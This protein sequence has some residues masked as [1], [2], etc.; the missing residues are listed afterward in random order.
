MPVQFLP[1]AAYEHGYRTAVASQPRRVPSA[2]RHIL[3]S[4][5]AAWFQGYDKALCDSEAQ[6]AQ[7]LADFELV[8]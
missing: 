3:P 6:R 7:V 8:A 5:S 1:A 4:V 2:I